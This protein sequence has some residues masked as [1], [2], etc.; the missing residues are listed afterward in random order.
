MRAYQDKWVHVVGGFSS[1]IFPRG[2]W[3]RRWKN[4]SRK[5]GLLI[6][7]FLSLPIN[8]AAITDDKLRR[9]LKLK[10]QMNRKREHE[11]VSGIHE[12]V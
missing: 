3:H 10:L 12:G 8:E 4:R 9:R 6:L 11:F 5:S 7:S 2:I 1:S